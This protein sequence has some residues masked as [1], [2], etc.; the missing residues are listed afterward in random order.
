[1]IYYQMIKKNIKKQIKEYFNINSTTKLRVRQIERELKLPLPSVIRY[2]K[3]LCEENILTTYEISNIKLFLADRTSGE[4]LLEKR[5]Y[6]I[7]SLKKL[8]RYI[9][10]ELDN[11]T[12][13]LFGSYSKGEDIES[14]DI[15]LY[16]ECKKEDLKLEKFKKQLHRNIQLHFKESFNNYPP[17]L[18]NNIINGLVLEGYLEV[19]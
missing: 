18:K 7:K 2:L 19:F 12:I 6:N 9:K 8:V 11:P 16:L 17:E 5:L 14:S 1:M 13:I 3:E 10:K 15:D 4:F